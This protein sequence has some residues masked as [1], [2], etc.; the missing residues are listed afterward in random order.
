MLK[1]LHFG[2]S[3]FQAVPD[4][5]TQERAYSVF[6]KC[7]H[8]ISLV[9]LQMWEE[10]TKRSANL[11]KEFLPRTCC[12]FIPTVLVVFGV[13]HDHFNPCL[14]TSHG[15]SPCLSWAAEAL[16]HQCEIIRC[17]ESLDQ[18]WKSQRSILLYAILY[19]SLLYSLG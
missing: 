2:V 3:G 4:V 9:T 12:S 17:R 14:F 11:T 16:E 8:T 7:V 5:N 19:Y 18:E 10:T 6:W 13:F 15:F 1:H